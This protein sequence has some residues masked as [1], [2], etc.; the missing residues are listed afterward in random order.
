VPEYIRHPNTKCLVCEKAIYKRP[1]Q[2]EVNKGKVFCSM[3]CYGISNRKEKPCIICGRK[4]LAGLH[5]KTCSRA[6]SNK[7]RSGIKY[8]INA[9]RDKAREQRAIKLRLIK[10]RGNTCER[11]GYHRF[12]II[13]V[14]HRDRNRQNNSSENLMLLCPNCHTEEHY[15]KSRSLDDSIVPGRGA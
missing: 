10:E 8:N 2:I 3:A 5:K 15:L 1:V 6:C 14:H 13:E 9:P 7:N 4:I 11:C 12:P